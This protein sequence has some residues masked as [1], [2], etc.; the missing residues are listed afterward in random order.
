MPSSA[1]DAMLWRG[2]AALVS[3]M[4]EHTADITIADIMT[5]TY[6]HPTACHETGAGAWLLSGQQILSRLL[7]GLQGMLTVHQ[8]LRFHCGPYYSCGLYRHG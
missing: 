2:S 5:F 6:V 8:H 1:L 3:L 7:L 4:S